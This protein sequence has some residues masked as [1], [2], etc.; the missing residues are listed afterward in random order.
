MFL[1]LGE[2]LP[3]DCLKSV[4]AFIREESD[5][6]QGVYM[7][8][9]SMGVA[10]YGGRGDI[11]TRLKSHNKNYPSELLY[12]SFYIIRN[13]KHE[14]EIETAILRA[15]GSQMTLNERKTAL[16]LKVGNVSDYEPGTH[17]IERQA[18]KG[19]KKAELKSGLK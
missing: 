5:D 7:A 4:A 1:Y 2:K 19:R 17:F 14:R 13:K 12:F 9:D 11:F 10:R 8:H 15:A 6:T 18:K 16:G 3:F